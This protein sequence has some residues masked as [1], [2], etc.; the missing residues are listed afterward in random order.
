[1]I[2]GLVESIGSQG[3]LQPI[4][5]Q[6]I[7]GGYQLIAGAH[8]LEAMR[9]L[10]RK[11]IMAGVVKNIDADHPKL[12]EIDENLIGADLSPAEEAASLASRKAIYER[13]YP[14]TKQGAAPGKAGGGKQAKDCNLQSFVDDTAKK[15]GKDRATISRA[16]KRG[17]AI[18]DVVDL[19]GT[20]LDKGVELDAL[21]KLPEDEQ[22]DLK[23][24]A[25]AGEPVTAR[26]KL[27]R[28]MHEVGFATLMAWIDKLSTLEEISV[29]EGLNTRELRKHRAS[30]RKAIEFLNGLDVQLAASLGDVLPE[31]ED[32]IIE[33]F[34]RL[35]R[36][37]Q[38]HCGLK[39]R[40]ISRGDA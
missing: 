35:D 6:V 2:D 40:S 34:K 25:K 13:L 14:E 15:T 23:E 9:R 4:V 12:A 38:T 22:S 26:S 17:K 24:R 19:A 5:V 33:L 30:T 39:L 31:P 20:S 11:T 37:A 3:L 16:A 10:G 28:I 36:Q 8:R 32:Q 29:P 21:P 18:P 7:G 1:V 27:N